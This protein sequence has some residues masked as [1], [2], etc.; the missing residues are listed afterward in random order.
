M[1]QYFSLFLE[2]AEL[3]RFS[4][5]S[6]TDIQRDC[7]DHFPRLP[8]TQN[9]VHATVRV[10]DTRNF[11]NPES[12]SSVLKRLRWRGQHARHEPI[13]RRGCNEGIVGSQRCKQPRAGYK[14]HSKQW[15]NLRCYQIC[16]VV[17]NFLFSHV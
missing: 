15:T 4:K 12:P 14:Y 6:H 13:D 7:A 1:A 17:M 11:S 9:D 10:D 8:G 5:V 3:C 16:D 2:N